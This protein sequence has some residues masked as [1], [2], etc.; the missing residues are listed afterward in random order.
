M[1]NE[2]K[3]LGA[4]FRTVRVKSGLTQDD[5]AART[6]VSVSSIRRLERGCSIGLDA[7]LSLLRG[8]G[9][10]LNAGAPSSDTSPKRRRATSQKSIRAQAMK[11]IR[12]LWAR[13]RDECA[14]FVRRDFE[15]KNKVEALFCLSCLENHGDRALWIRAKELRQ[16]L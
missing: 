2:L 11:E 6:G 5:L 15:P 9:H 7:Y 3:Q 14:W 1:D 4:S 8:I 12:S 13:H 10:G 16:C